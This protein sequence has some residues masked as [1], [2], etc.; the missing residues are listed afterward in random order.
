[1]KNQ[2]ITISLEAI[3][4][5]QKLQEENNFGSN[6]IKISFAPK[7]SCTREK[8][9]CYKYS[10]LMDVQEEDFQKDATLDLLEDSIVI[11]NF[12]VVIDQKS[13]FLLEGTTLEYHDSGDLQKKGFFFNNP[14][15]SHQCN[16]AMRFVST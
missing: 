8:D 6:G 1:M 12:L 7:E 15:N 9:K 4:A 16:C 14:N 2:I 10:L 11:E 3:L 13:A 5:L